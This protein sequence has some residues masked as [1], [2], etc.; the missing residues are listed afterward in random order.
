MN[1]E[2]IINKVKEIILKKL[3][4]DAIILFGSYARK[5]ERQ[6]SDIDVAIKPIEKIDKETLIDIQ[7]ILEEEINLD[8]HLINLYTIEE[9]F[10]YDILI[11]GETLYVKNEESF[12]EYKFKA[13]NDYLELNEDRKIII[14]KLKRTLYG[15]RIGDTK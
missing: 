4:V 13:Y 10:R 9:D 6:D 14:D 7:T 15:K 3:K 1:R 2:E 8:V 12:W 11:T 5:E